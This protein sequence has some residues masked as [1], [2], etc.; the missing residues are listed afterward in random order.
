M[1]RH[2]LSIGLVAALLAAANGCCVFDEGVYEP[3]GPGLG[4]DYRHCPRAAA[5]C[6]APCDAGGACGLQPAQR[7]CAPCA[8]CGAARDELGCGPYTD[9]HCGPLTWV[10]SLFCRPAFCGTGCGHRYYGEWYSD[11]PDCCDPCDFC[12]GGAPGCSAC[13][14]A[15]G[16]V[17]CPDC[18]DESVMAPRRATLLN[19]RAPARPAT[20]APRIVSQS[21]RPV[22]PAQRTASPST[23]ST[24]TRSGATQPARR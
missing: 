1:L 13:A 20:P 22:A 14:P 12:G 16:P 17:G 8:E 15:A 4:P 9:G 21:D 6:A 3:F 23:R 19:A 10:F 7:A 11:P 2:A 24:S 5:G 18:A